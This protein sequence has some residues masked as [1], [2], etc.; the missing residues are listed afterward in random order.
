M[1]PEK[2]RACENIIEVMGLTKGERGRVI[3]FELLRYHLSSSPPGLAVETVVRVAP[4]GRAAEQCA[5][6][7]DG[8]SELAAIE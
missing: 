2:D 1:E 3:G 4:W 6:N 7:F 8:I 5:G